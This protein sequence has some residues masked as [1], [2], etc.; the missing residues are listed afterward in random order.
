MLRTALLLLSLAPRA[1]AQGE[2]AAL[3]D[4]TLRGLSGAAESPAVLAGLRAQAA[5]LSRPP[6]PRLPP[7]FRA[8]PLTRQRTGYSCGPAALL[9]ALRYWG[10]FDGR[11]QDLYALLET[12]KK[13]G[14]ESPKLAE[15][16]R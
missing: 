14:T 7:G 1:S 2:P 12:T 5:R 9:G 8:V 11:E 10:V 6:R 4:Q 16:A 3:V 13:D 15:G